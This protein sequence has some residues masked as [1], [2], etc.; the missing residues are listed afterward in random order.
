[1][2]FLH[3]I[4]KAMKFFGKMKS[5]I[6]DKVH[7]PR[8]EQFYIKKCNTDTVFKKTGR[9]LMRTGSILDFA[10]HSLPLID[11]YNRIVIKMYR[12]QYNGIAIIIFL[13]LSP[14]I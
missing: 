5:Y 7:P 2:I 4:C 12:F 9:E 13:S 3:T 6:K 10:S 14:F 1:M 11:E 8:Q